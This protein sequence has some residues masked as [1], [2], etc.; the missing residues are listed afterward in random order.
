M[1]RIPKSAWI[2]STMA[3]FCM[4]GAASAAVFAG[5]PIAGGSAQAAAVC[6]VF[7]SGTTTVPF[8]GYGVVP[9]IGGGTLKLYYNSC[10]S[11]VAPGASCSIAAAVG[12][13]EAY[14]CYIQTTT[15]TAAL[16]GS[17]D[18]RNADGSTILLSTPLR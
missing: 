4:S 17:M 18:V 8:G 1:K 11:G 10:G 9:Q 6:Y 13:N 15:T 5:G 14:S 3:A 2:A 7:N 16:R 12:N